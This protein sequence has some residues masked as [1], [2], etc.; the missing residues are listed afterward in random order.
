VDVVTIV[1][2]VL[3]VGML[4]ALIV[5]MVGTLIP[6]F[7]ASHQKIWEKSHL[8]S[9]G[10]QK[11]RN[12]LLIWLSVPLVVA[13]LTA[14]AA[15]L[16]WGQFREL[17]QTQGYI[18]GHDPADDFLFGGIGLMLVA[19]GCGIF[20]GIIRAKLKALRILHREEG[21]STPS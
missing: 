11:R 6:S 2:G 8:N 7:K 16:C 14:Y 3:F 15:I 18:S 9:K 13:A 10:Y 21:K 4:L 12:E 5:E 17:S 19:S 1:I 20:A